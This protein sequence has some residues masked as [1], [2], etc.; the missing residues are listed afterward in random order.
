MEIRFDAPDA[1][2]LDYY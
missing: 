1:C 2:Y